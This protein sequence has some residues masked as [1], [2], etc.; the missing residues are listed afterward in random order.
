MVLIPDL[1]HEALNLLVELDQPLS[2]LP[3][4]DLQFNACELTQMPAAKVQQVLVIPT[5][6]HKKERKPLF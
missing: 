1:E 4:F 3:D 6:T 2:W 5:R